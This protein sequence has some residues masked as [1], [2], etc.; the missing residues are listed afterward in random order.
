MYRFPRFDH[1]LILDLVYEGHDVRGVLSKA[2]ARL[3]PRLRV[4]NVVPD[5]IL[6]APG[7]RAVVGSTYQKATGR[8][9][10]AP[11]VDDLAGH[12]GLLDLG[13]GEVFKLVLPDEGAKGDVAAVIVGVA[14]SAEEYVVHAGTSDVSFLVFHPLPG[15]SASRCH[16]GMYAVNGCM[17]KQQ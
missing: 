17:D 11:Y 13:C 3:L 12:L 8:I 16:G 9:E 7:G 14:S 10:A 5:G 4:P 6:V 2:L 15:C 1:L